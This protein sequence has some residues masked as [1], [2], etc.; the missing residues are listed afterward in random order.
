MMNT[1]GTDVSDETDRLRLPF[2]VHR[3]TA[4]A[5]HLRDHVDRRLFWHQEVDQCRSSVPQ[6]RLWNF[7]L[8]DMT[9]FDACISWDLCH[10]V[11]SESSAINHSLGD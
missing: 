3:D 4:Q 6:G 7:R 11:V 2:V 9:L 1:E 5:E 10:S 8:T